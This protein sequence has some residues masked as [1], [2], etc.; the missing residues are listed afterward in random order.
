MF[1]SPYANKRAD[2]DGDSAEDDK[3]QYTVCIW[4]LC[5]CADWQT[6]I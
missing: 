6:P 4:T 1:K 3:L 2:G 5:L